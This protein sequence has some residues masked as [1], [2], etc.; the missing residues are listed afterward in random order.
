MFRWLR[1]SALPS[2]HPSNTDGLKS[3]K[4]RLSC[5]ALCS[6]GGPAQGGSRTC[7]LFVSCLDVDGKLQLQRAVL[8][9]QAEV[10]ELH[11][12]LSVL[13]QPAGGRTT[14]AYWRKAAGCKSKEKPE[15]T[16]RHRS[17]GRTKY[18]HIV[19]TK[20]GMVSH[21]KCDVLCKI[22]IHVV[23]HAWPASFVESA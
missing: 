12:W 7:T 5:A 9:Q 15:K 22:S 10:E 13:E 20:S 2:P 21:L 1:C 23:D 16:L 11:T 14:S 17:L 8:A 3:L 19:R 6:V 4:G 18:L